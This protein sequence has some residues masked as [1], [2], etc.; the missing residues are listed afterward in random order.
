VE[1]AAEL[2]FY[3]AKIKPQRT[4]ETEELKQES[5]FGRT[6]RMLK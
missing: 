6:V 3:L 5:N 2:I 4:V 1:R